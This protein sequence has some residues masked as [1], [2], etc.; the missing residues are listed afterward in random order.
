MVVYPDNDDDED[1]DDTQSG[2]VLSMDMVWKKVY[3]L[4]KKTQMQIVK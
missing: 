4:L 3:I 2:Q 1:D